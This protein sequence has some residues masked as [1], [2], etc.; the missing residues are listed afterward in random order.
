V[1]KSGQKE[2]PTSTLTNSPRINCSFIELMKN[3]KERGIFLGR[4][5]ELQG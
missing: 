2:E 1:H 4:R 5:R 3:S